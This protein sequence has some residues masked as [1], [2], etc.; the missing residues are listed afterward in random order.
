MHFSE[1]IWENFMPDGM[2]AIFIP[3]GF[4]TKWGE[5]LSVLGSKERG[6]LQ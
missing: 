1:A 3:L 2:S 5:M 4:L 6:R